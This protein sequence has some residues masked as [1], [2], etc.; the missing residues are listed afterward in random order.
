M[1][2]HWDCGHVL[3]LV[4]LQQ[5][6]RPGEL[7]DVKLAIPRHPPMTCRGIH[8]GEDRKVNPVGLHDP[9]FDGSNNFVV[10]S[11]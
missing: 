5:V 1:E 8:I 11:C 6:G 7:T 10:A 3:A 9:L 4:P 2:K